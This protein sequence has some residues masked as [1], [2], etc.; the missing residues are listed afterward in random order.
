LAVDKACQILRQF[1][2]I[3]LTEHTFS[4]H[5]LVQAVIRD[6]LSEHDRKQWAEAA[7]FMIDDAFPSNS[8][9]V[10]T[11][12]S[13]IALLPHARITCKY[14]EDLN[15]ALDKV[16]SILGHT[17]SYL[18]ARAEYADAELLFRKALKIRETQLGPDYPDVAESLSGLALLLT[19]RGQY[20]A[21]EPVYRRAL[22]IRETQLGP[23]H[24]KVA[25][26]LS[27]LYKQWVA[28]SDFLWGWPHGF[29]WSHLLFPSPSEI[30]QNH[31]LLV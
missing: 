8:D 17:A 13:C 7:V 20:A 31:P 16:A 19:V 10:R 14:A 15:V 2:L 26:S 24:L 18:F 4:M 28:L 25:E 21:A 6:S 30:R 1:S 5:H 23:D 29:T 12:Q 9:D 27:G 11:W 22:K 3:Q